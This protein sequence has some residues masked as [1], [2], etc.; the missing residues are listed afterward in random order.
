ML[1]AVY[2]IIG[3]LVVRNIVLKVIERNLAWK[4]FGKTVEDMHFLERIVIDALC[5]TD[6]V[7]SSD[8]LKKRLSDIAEEHF[9][10]KVEDLRTTALSLPLDQVGSG[11]SWAYSSEARVELSNENEVCTRNM[12]SALF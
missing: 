8:L 6:N 7:V 11:R 4:S 2:V 5:C 10:K 12:L 3:S 1:Q 9:M